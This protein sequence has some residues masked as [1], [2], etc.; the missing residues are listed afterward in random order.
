MIF[1]FI[2]ADH[3][4]GASYEVCIGGEVV[5][6][7]DNGEKQ[8]KEL[9]ENTDKFTLLPNSIAFVTLEPYFQIP[10]YLA[11][12]FNLKISHI[13]KGLLLGTGPLV[14]PGFQGK[15]SIPLH[16]LTANEYV[17][18]KGDGLIQ[19]EFTKLSNEKSWRKNQSSPSELYQ[20]FNIPNHV[21]PGRTVHDYLKKALD[22]NKANTVISSIPAAMI[23]AHESVKQAEKSALKAQ[24]WSK[25][26][27]IVGIV[28][29]FLALAAIIYSGWSLVHG[30]EAR[31]DSYYS[32]QIQ[33]KNE[34]EEL[35]HSVESLLERIEDLEET[36]ALVESLPDELSLQP[37][38]S[39]A[40]DT[41]TTYPPP[42]SNQVNE[43]SP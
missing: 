7:D 31:I 43:V 9:N 27:G 2:P 16:N 40:E 25:G 37:S 10:H 38:E 11:L 28:G 17:F 24:W 23:D 26:I 34:N 39:V 35:K 32:E 30:I 20:G 33:L 15:L 13:Y 5:Y 8:V 12:R 41:T 22:N 42:E 14:D 6:W 18:K 1:P 3:L 4:K 36:L 21:K 19:L 29:T